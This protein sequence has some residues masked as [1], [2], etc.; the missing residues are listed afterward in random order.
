[1]DFHEREHSHLHA[2]ERHDRRRHELEAGA[3][4]VFLGNVLVL[5]PMLLNAHA[6]AQY[7][8]RFQFFAPRLLGVLRAPTSP[9]FCAP[10]SLAAGSAFKPGGGE[11]INAMIVALAPSW[12]NFIRARHLF[13]F[14]LAPQCSLFS[15]AL[16]PFLPAG[17]SAPFLLLIGQPF[18]CG[19]QQSRRLRP[20]AATPS[21]FQTFGEFFRFFI[22]SLTGVVGFWATSR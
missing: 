13:R 20:H 7:A 9:P 5:I 10:S 2:R 8:S 15:A 21:K 6:G 11:A 22:P 14:L 12:A 17:I 1:V 19:A 3:L 4:T 18:S 16:K